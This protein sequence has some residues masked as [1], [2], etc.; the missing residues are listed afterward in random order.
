MD[1]RE[2]PGHPRWVQCRPP[3]ASLA[4]RLGACDTSLVHLS[5]PRVLLRAVLLVVGGGF[6]LWK[7]WGAHLAARAA[8]AS[9]EALLLSRVA[10]V[11]AL[12]GSLGLVAAGLA[13]LALRQRKRTHT[14]QL[15]DLA[16]RSEDEGPGAGPSG[17][18]A[19]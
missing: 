3:H 14:L 10:L 13:L 11:E 8:G 16:K 9:P 12:M 5:R 2:A 18:D 6:L 7:A 4:F 1:G 15:G 17:P 19:P